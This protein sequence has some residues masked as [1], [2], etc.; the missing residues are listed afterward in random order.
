[1]FHRGSFQPYS[2]TFDLQVSNT[3]A[4]FSIFFATKKK[5]LQQHCVNNL[6]RFL[7]HL[8]CRAKK[9][10]CWIFANLDSLCGKIGLLPDGLRHIGIQVSGTDL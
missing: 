2:E 1:M 3:P 7:S 10:E 8:T 4:Y 5:V 9:L 6:K